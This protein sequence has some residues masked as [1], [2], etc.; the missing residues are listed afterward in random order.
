[1]TTPRATQVGELVGYLKRQDW[2]LVERQLAEAVR[3]AQSAKAV[4]DGYP[5]GGGSGSKGGEVPDP[6]H[7]AATG[8]DPRDLVAEHAKAA[9]TH[10]EDAVVHVQ[11]CLRRLDLI[12]QMTTGA[13]LNPEPICWAMARVGSVEPVHRTSD[14]G[15]RLREARP[16]GKWAYD[17]V[18]HQ[19]RL[20]TVE[21]CRA[22]AEGRRVRVS[23]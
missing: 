2:K 7:A 20:P 9:A 11:G 16:L 22:R 17:F 18:V 19:G 14:V 1:M 21:E 8:R 3:R 13:D 15:G 23:A 4:R 5:S 12:E 10:L 6:T